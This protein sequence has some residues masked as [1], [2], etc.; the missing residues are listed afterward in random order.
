MLDCYEQERYI[1]NQKLASFLG[2]ELFKEYDS[3]IEEIKA[4]RHLKVFECQ[5]SKFE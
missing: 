5:K 1:Y 3:F 4:V 2:P